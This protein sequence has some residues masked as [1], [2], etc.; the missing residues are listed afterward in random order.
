M[1]LPERFI[2]QATRYVMGRHTYAVH[3]HC[4]W[5][6]ANWSRIP[7]AERRVIQQDLEAAFGRDD[8][9]RQMRS[10]DLRSLGDDCD[11][12]DWQRVRALYVTPDAPVAKTRGR[13]K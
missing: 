1:N 9:A 5:L 10:K 11:R 13:R 7:E 12:Q 8:R 4:E 2:H 6:E 3:E